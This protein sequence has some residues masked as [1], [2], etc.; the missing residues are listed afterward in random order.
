MR[1]VLFPLFVNLLVTLPSKRN[2][3]AAG[4]ED[5]FRGYIKI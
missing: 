5:P 3:S 2:T 1:P 4:D